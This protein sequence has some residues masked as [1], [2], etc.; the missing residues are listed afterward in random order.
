MP[1]TGVL[2]DMVGRYSS[3]VVLRD[4]QTTDRTPVSQPHH[5]IT[6]TPHHPHTPS[7]QHNLKTKHQKDSI[8]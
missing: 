4:R 7:P 5:P 8:V 2:L 1:E 3:G 6:P